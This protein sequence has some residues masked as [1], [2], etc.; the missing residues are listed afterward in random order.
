MV[1]GDKECMRAHKKEKL[2][3][4]NLVAEILHRYT[5][6]NSKPNLLPNN[7]GT[8][9]KFLPVASTMQLTSL[10]GLAIQ[11]ALE[12]ASS[13]DGGGFQ[14]FHLLLLGFALPPLFFMCCV[15]FLKEEEETDST[16]IVNGMTKSQR[17]LYVT[18][19]LTIK[20]RV[21]NM[22]LSASHHYLY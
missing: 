19:K 13:D 9:C 16:T 5:S 2:S 6:A 1:P 20:V 3:H 12:D 22:S 17:K 8:T 21:F 18:N 10:Y 11:R 14:L 7:K 15:C 4:Y